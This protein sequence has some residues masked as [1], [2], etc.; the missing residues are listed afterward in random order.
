MSNNVLITVTIS[1][2]CLFLFII[3]A[4]SEDENPVESKNDKALVG[5]WKLTK[6][7]SEYQGVSETLTEDQLDSLGLVWTI[8]LEDDGTVD[9][10][11]NMSGPLATMP[12]SWITS[13]NKL[14]LTLTGPS[15]DT[16]TIVYEY[17]VDGEILK[18]SWQLPAGTEFYA[19]FTKQ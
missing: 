13:A 5:N 18:L 2:L 6:M 4:C 11:T 15:S 10:S 8:K 19:E 12:G 16:S 7:R 14:S 1:L 9:Q 3:C 17:S